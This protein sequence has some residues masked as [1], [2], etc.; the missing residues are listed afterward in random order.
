MINIYTGRPGEGKTFVMTSLALEALRKGRHVW[1]NYRLND[2]VIAQNGW[3]EQVTY[4][5][6]LTELYNAEEGLILMD[7]VHVYLNS[8]RWDRLPAEFERK[9]QQHR[10]DGLDIIGTAQSIDRVDKVFREL[11]HGFYRCFKLMGSNGSDK[12]A[13]PWGLILVFKY[14]P[15]DVTKDEARRAALGFPEFFTITKEVAHFYDSFAKVSDP[16]EYV[17]LEHIDKYCEKCGFS[18]CVHE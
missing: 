18:K 4:Y 12:L 8:R 1:A 14:K 11:V 3:T 9:L 2:E 10:K 5:S 6:E 13:T 16:K 17:K 7:E 15:E